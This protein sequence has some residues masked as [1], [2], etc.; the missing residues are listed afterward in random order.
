[1][2]KL[3]KNSKLNDTAEKEIPEEDIPEIE[4]REERQSDRDEDECCDFTEEAVSVEVIKKGT[5]D[6]VKKACS[7]ENCSLTSKD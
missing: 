1:M 4:H 3:A 2:G 6:K 5:R 7:C